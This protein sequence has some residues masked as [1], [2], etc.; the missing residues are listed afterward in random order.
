M[1]SINSYR[2][3]IS[4]DI[5]K[6]I[7]KAARLITQENPPKNLAFVGLM[8]D[9][10]KKIH[11]DIDLI[12]FPSK[13]C[14]MGEAILELTDFYEKLEKKI[15]EKNEKY[16]LVPCNKH[17]LQQL[18]YY[19]ATL[20]EGSAGLIPIHTLFFPD[21]ASLNKTP[22]KFKAKVLSEENII[23]IFGGFEDAQKETN[24]EKFSFE[25]YSHILDFELYARIKTFPKQ[26]VRASAQHLFN[27]LK[28]KYNLDLSDQIPHNL[29]EIDKH[30][31]NLII[32]LDKKI[33]ST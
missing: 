12:F 30:V 29:E 3:T 25:P 1:E 28:V 33:Y 11:H 26:L 19:L 8:I 7:E 22:E 2:P 6:E 5:V 24:I 17:H 10:N 9:Y 27:Y 14:K 21:K 23:V 4:K 20:Q 31:K 16:Y 18:V 32:S 13:K 15:K